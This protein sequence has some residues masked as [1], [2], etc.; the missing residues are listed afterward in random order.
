MTAFKSMIA[1][2]FIAL[3]GAASDAGP[4]Q[5]PGVNYEDPNLTASSDYASDSA[6]SC[7]TA[8]K[9]QKLRACL[10]KAGVVTS[11]EISDAAQSLTESAPHSLH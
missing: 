6:T 8:L 3:A 11:E 9:G 10:I 1:I 4:A 5:L 2:L 7:P